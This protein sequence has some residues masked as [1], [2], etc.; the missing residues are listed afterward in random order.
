MEEDTVDD[1]FVV[2][3][4]NVPEKTYSKIEIEAL[5]IQRSARVK[6][7]QLKGS[8]SEVWKYVGVVLVDGKP[9]GFAACR[10]CPDKVFKYER[11]GGISHL[12][13]HVKSYCPYGRT[14]TE[15][16]NRYF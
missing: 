10:K 2:E 5:L 14:S 12:R 13:T 16:N 7:E 1:V 11:G 9:T 15:N 3:D 6:L 4:G 8:F